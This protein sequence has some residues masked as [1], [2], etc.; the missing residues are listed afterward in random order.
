[1]LID[2]SGEIPVSVLKAAEQAFNSASWMKI[3]QA[4]N[5]TSRD[6]IL[7]AASTNLRHLWHVIRITGDPEDPKRSPRIDLALAEEQIKTYGR[8][9][10]WVMAY[11]LGLFPPGS[12]NT[13]FDADQVASAMARHLTIDQYDFSQKRLGVDVAR[14]GDDRTVIFPRQGLAAFRPVEMRGARTQ[15]IAARVAEAK[16]KWNSHLELIDGTGGFGSGVIDCLLQAGHS[17]LEVHFSGKAVDPRYLNKRAEMW[18]EMSNW[19]KRGASIPN[20]PTLAKEL[21]TPTYTFSNGKFQLE[22]KEQIKA[23]L[24]FSPDLADALALTFALPEM[25]RDLMLPGSS[26][27]GKVLTE[28]DPY[29]ELKEE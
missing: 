20:I 29:R 22:S 25:P 28:F 24:K 7:Y 16:L 2:E 3:M 18:F 13:L 1:M 19:I 11:I 8:D 4:G 23:R 17:P 26:K 10:P 6:G 9:D 14:F 27:P 21:T 12:I 15:D 5:P